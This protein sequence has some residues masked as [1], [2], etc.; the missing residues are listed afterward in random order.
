MMGGIS[1]SDASAKGNERLFLSQLSLF[2]TRKSFLILGIIAS[3][4]L[5]F[6]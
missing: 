3:S 1:P 5:Y 6:A 4:S 2:L